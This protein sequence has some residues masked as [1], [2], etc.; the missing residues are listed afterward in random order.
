MLDAS[1][2]AMTMPTSPNEVAA[3]VRMLDQTAAVAERINKVRRTVLR[4][5]RENQNSHVILP[6]LP[7]WSKR[8]A[9]A[10]AIAC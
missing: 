2:A 10:A 5:D 7:I 9:E 4:M 6:E 8:P 3:S 1:L